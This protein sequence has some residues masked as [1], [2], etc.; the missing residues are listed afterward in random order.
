MTACSTAF[1]VSN[2]NPHAE[3]DLRFWGPPKELFEIPQR[4]QIEL[5]SHGFVGTGR[6][7]GSP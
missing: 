3:S 1:A 6:F 2:V 4:R 5:V 7:E